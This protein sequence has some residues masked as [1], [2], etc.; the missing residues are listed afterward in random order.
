MT[1]DATPRARKAVLLAAGRGRRLGELTE[2][3]PKCLVEIQGRPLLDHWF[4]SLARHGFDEVLVNGHHLAERVE[5]FLDD[6]R[7]RHALTVRYVREPALVGTGGTLLANAEFVAKEDAFLVAHADNWTDVDLG[8]LVR[9]HAA[10]RSPLTLALFRTRTPESCGIVEE[11]AEDGRIERFVEKPAAPKSDLASAAIFVATPTV[12][13]ELR[14]VAAT[15]PAVAQ[16]NGE[17]DFSREVLPR[18]EGRMYGYE[19]P[20]HNVDVGTPE[21]L[22]RAR[23][24]AARAPTT[25]ISGA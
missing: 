1:A 8:A 11:I 4:A 22:E 19:L 7:G 16:A 10:N 2:H 3:T 9:F 12:L 24:L 5:A 25:E 6:A 15:R 20:G 14:E 21:Q 13:D 18:F 23:A 17:F